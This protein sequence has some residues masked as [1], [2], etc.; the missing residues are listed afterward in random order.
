MSA[1]LSMSYNDC[2]ATVTIYLRLNK[3]QTMCLE[4]PA[5]FMLMNERDAHFRFAREM[6]MR[7][8]GERCYAL[9]ELWPEIH[10]RLIQCVVQQHPLFQVLFNQQQGTPD[11]RFMKRR[12]ALADLHPELRRLIP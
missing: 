7:Y 3:H 4:L 12:K 2:D 6:E 8:Q 11:T 1:L 10:T 9:I 5:S